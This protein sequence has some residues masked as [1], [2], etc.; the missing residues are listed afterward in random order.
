MT[1]PSTSI[2]SFFA[3]LAPWP[4]FSNDAEP[5]WADTRTVRISTA[6]NSDNTPGG[7]TR[8]RNLGSRRRSR[9]WCARS[10]R[11]ASRP[12]WRPSSCRRGPASPREPRVSIG[13][14]A[15]QCR[16]AGVIP[17]WRLRKLG[18][19]GP[20]ASMVRSRGPRT[21]GRSRSPRH[22][23][24]LDRRPRCRRSGPDDRRADAGH[25]R[26]RG[27]LDERPGRGSTRRPGRRR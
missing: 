2:A 7:Q 25:H 5:G 10:G 18:P 16:P 17:R 21:G 11:R 6:A 23:H 13:S 9:R 15:R 14:I 26:Q 20:R 24:V 22:G 8:V 4:L 19:A 27:R 3:N 12:T 1:V